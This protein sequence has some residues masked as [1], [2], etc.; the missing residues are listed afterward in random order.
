M[1][2]EPPETAEPANETTTAP[3]QDWGRIILCVVIA[4]LAALAVHY[5]AFQVVIAGTSL[6]PTVHALVGMV[7]F[8]LAGFVSFSLLY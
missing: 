2:E 8:F 1:S 7:L 4:I 3:E 6:H 5:V